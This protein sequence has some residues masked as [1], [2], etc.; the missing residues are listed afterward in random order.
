MA[1]LYPAA[2]SRGEGHT[3]FVE[4]SKTYEQNKGFDANKDGVIRVAEVSFK[5]R[6]MFQKGLSKAIWGE[7]EI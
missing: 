4:G 1:I 5:V 6:S 2:V 3:L 7:F